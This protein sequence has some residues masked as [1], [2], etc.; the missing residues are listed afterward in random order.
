MYAEIIS[1]FLH[2]DKEKVKEH[3]LYARDTFHIPIKYY[4]NHQLFYCN[5]DEELAGYEKQL[6]E[7]R[8]QYEKRLSDIT[9]KTPD[10]AKEYMTTTCASCHITGKEILD[11]ELYKMTPE[12]IVQWKAA[13][14]ARADARVKRLMEKSGKDEAF[15]R[16][17]MAKCKCIFGIAMGEYESTRC[18][19]LSDEKLST[20]ANLEDSRRLRAKYITVDDEVLTNKILF[21][22]TYKEF[23]GR[24]YWVNEHTSYEEFARFID[25]KEEVFCKPIDLHGALGVY[26]V[27]V[28]KDTKKLYDDFM[29]QPKLLVEELL[30]QHP[31]MSSF[32]SKSINTVRVFTILKDDVFDAFAAFVRFGKDGI[33]DNISAGGI[34]CGV[35]EKTGKIITP[36]IGMDGILYEKHPVSG[37]EF[38]GF[39]IPF[40][41]EILTTCEK[42]LRKVPGVNFAGFDVAITKDGIAIVEG[43]CIPCLSIYQSFFAYK[44]QGRKYKYEKY[45]KD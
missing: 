29:A 40:W 10:E 2:T 13:K 11:G 5:S 24:D 36:A 34:G 4:A 19:E 18:Y 21:N 27:K 32:Y 25:G 43:N 16:K 14:K 12:E 33:A 41:N 38:L 20:Y 45:L 23:L 15:I 44:Y 8:I 22:K 9:G 30:C 28:E 6:T 17:H 39:Q 3:M 35:D 7:S 42:A 26:K 37:K 31:A 1:E